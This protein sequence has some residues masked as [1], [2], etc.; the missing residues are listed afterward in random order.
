[1]AQTYR[2]PGYDGDG[3]TNLAVY[4]DGNWYIMRSWDG[5]QVAIGWGGMAQDIL[6]PADYDGDG[7]TDLAVYRDGNW[8]I[9]RSWDGSIT[10]IGWGK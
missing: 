7:K 1:M 9:I 6:V 2:C 8:F 4:R 5:G 10:I 3:K